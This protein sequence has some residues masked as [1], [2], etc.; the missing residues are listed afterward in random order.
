MET[1]A[2]QCLQGKCVAVLMT[3]GV[4]QVEYTSPRQFLEERGARVTLLSPKAVGEAVQAFNHMTPG[5]TFKV[6]MNVQDARSAD[7]DA[8]LLPGGAANADQLRLSQ[9]AISFIREFGEEDKPIAAICHGPRTL[10]D[11]GIAQSKHMTSSPDLQ[12]DLRNAGAEWTDDQVVVDDMLITSRNPGDI[13][14][15]NDALM[16]ELMMASGTDPGPTS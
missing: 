3:D 10:I 5:D 1:N 14:A 12:T 4:E 6:E 2:D 11:A 8:L 15:F 9:E 13:P 16:K 7:F